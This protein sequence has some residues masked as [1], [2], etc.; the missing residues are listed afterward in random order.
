MSLWMKVS[1]RHETLG[2]LGAAHMPL[3]G[4]SQVTRLSRLI[5]KRAVIFKSA[6]H[7][8]TGC[9]CRQT[10]DKDNLGTSQ[11]GIIYLSIYL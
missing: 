11:F 10:G 9:R 7:L 3:T 4:L 2:G 8:L 5:W 1:D 6:V